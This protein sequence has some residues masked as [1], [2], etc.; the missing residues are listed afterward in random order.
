MAPFASLR[1]RRLAASVALSLMLLVVAVPDQARAT[2]CGYPPPRADLVVEGE[3]LPGHTTRAGQLVSPARFKTSRYIRGDGPPVLRVATGTRLS[4]D[5]K[6]VEETE[7]WPLAAAG[8]RWRLQAR[9]PRNAS[10]TSEWTRRVVFADTCVGT[11]RISAAS[12]DPAANPRSDDD[13]LLTAALM[14]GG[15]I[16][17]MIGGAVALVWRHRARPAGL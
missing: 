9:R 12:V 5:G 2:S 3:F 13:G 11:E 16:A 14:L 10:A 8:E 15:G 7:L 1:E 4:R 6:W 17:V